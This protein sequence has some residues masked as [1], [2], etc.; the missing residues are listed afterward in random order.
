M[1]EARI[2]LTSADP[3][4]PLYSVVMD[5]MSEIFIRYPEGWASDRDLDPYAW[6]ELFANPGT[7]E[8]LSNV[9]AYRRQEAAQHPSEWRV[10]GTGGTGGTEG[11]IIYR[12]EQIQAMALRPEVAAW[13]VRAANGSRE[14]FCTNCGR[15][16]DDPD[17]W[18][19][20]L[21]TQHPFWPHSTPPGVDPCPHGFASAAGCGACEF[22]R[23]RGQVADVLGRLAGPDPS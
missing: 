23:Q 5:E 8:L 9:T 22:Y 10:G 20:A 18:C 11:H 1:A 21:D 4:P 3:E 16:A 7:V 14:G 12:G 13:L 6:G 2:T 15:P 17:P 19:G